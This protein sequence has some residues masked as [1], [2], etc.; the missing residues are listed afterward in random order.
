M[1]S[2]QLINSI[3]Y[4]RKHNNKDAKDI[5]I[6]VED[7]NSIAIRCFMKDKRY[8]TIIFFHGNAEICKD[9]DDIASYYNQHKINIIVSDYRGYG[10]SSG[11]PNKDNL[12]KDSLTVFDF[13]FEYLKKNKYNLNLIPMGRSLGSAS[14]SHIIKHRE[15]K[16]KGCIIE[17]G[18]ATEYPLLNLM[19]INPEDISFS[20]KDGFENLDKLKSYSKALLVIHADLDNI[21]PFSQAELIMIECKSNTKELFKV[22]GANHN[23]I[24]MYAR[25]EY[26][27]KIQ[28]FVESL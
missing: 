6:N 19:N 21:V 2:N 14:V 28:S 9:Y 12:H 22:E 25:D 8:P 5:L 17:S 26:F 27:I 11:Q 16:I 23:N 10:L 1:H 24:L 7:N 4:P 13:T 15:S 3:F 18:F 20:L